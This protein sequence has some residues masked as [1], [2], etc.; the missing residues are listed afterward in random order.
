LIIST[1]I[2]SGCKKQDPKSQEQLYKL[3]YVPFMKMALRYTQNEDDAKDILNKSFFKILTKIKT[4]EGDENNFYAWCKTILIHESLDHIK[5]LA[6]KRSFY[7]LEPKDDDV[8][9]YPESDFT[10]ESELILYY[11]RQLPLKTATVFN[12]FALE[13]YSHKEISEL[14]GINEG[15]SKWHLHSAREKLQNWIFNSKVK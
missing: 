6:F 2:L 1:H 8:I 13:G 15:N 11:I 12:L 14:I 7:T 9:I 10:T 3:C 4:F 5:S